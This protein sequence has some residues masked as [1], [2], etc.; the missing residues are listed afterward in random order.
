MTYG[1]FM[2]SKTAFLT[3]RKIH[4]PRGTGNF[5]LVGTYYVLSRKHEDFRSVFKF[6]L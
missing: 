3:R 6:K 2:F 1:V 4:I 5:R